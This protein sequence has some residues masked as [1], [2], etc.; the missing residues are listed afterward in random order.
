M[1]FALLSA[2]AAGSGSEPQRWL[3]AVV[4]VRQ[5]STVCSG[6]FVDDAGTVVT[7]YHCVASGGPVWVTDRAGRV[8]R[9]KVRRT[10]VASDLAV[11]DTAAEV[12]RWLALRDEPV[13]GEA[14]FAL[15]HPFGVVAPTGFLQGTLR[16]SV[17]GGLVSAVG[18]TAVQVTA[19]INPGNSGGPLVDRDG[20]ILGVVSRRLA[21]D[22]M[23]FAA[24]SELVQALLDTE[25][26]K[27]SPLGGTLAL[28]TRMASFL[29]AGGTLSFGGQA[30]V[31]FRD[32]VVFSAGASGSPGARWEAARG[33]AV[34][35]AI[36]DARVGL[37]QRLFR[38]P[39]TVRL[40]ATGGVVLLRRLRFDD[41][42]YPNIVD[43]PSLAVG[44][45]L[46]MQNVGVDVVWLPDQGALA[47]V[48]LR[49][50]GV[51]RVF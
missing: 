28:E 38:S 42:L 26:H 36:A 23:G 9:G 29:G 2:L 17:S 19:P 7:S 34:R 5:G 37:R 13:V 27:P 51:M 8:S 22:G 14:V 32:R 30:E 31:A 25:D 41:G 49:W 47:T 3:D 20:R 46:R 18:P 1:L 39:W 43:T 40:D 44:G 15:G 4:L 16:W 21:G 11:V 24:R 48:C 10:H 35:W 6:A 12:D 45:A 50:P 33:V